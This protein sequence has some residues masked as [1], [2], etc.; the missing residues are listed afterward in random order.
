MNIVNTVPSSLNSVIIS[1]TKEVKSH[2]HISCYLKGRHR[3]VKVAAMVDSGATALF[4]DKK[5][6][7]S[8]KMWQTPLEHPI[9]LHNIDG[10]LN[11]AGSITHKVKLSL[12]VGSDEEIFEFYVT[13]LGPEKVILG[14][15]WL[16]Y[17]NPTINW[18]EGTMHLGADQGMS[19]EPLE[20]KLTRIAAN[21]MERRRLLSEKVMD[22]IQ[23][24]IF[25]LAGFTYSQQIAE[26]ANRAK[27]IRTFEE[28][29]PEP[30]RDFAKVFSEE[31]SHRLPK[32]QPWDHAIDLEPDAITH[33]K[34]KSYPMS[35]AEQVELDKWL[36]ENL[37]KGY[38]RPS[39][40]PMASPVFFIKKKDGKLR[41]VQDYRRLNKIT[42]KDRYPLPLAADIVNRLTGAQLFTK[43]DVR[44]GITTSVLSQEMNG[45]Q[46]S[47]PIGWR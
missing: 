29:V 44:W 23:D 22:T 26:K 21:R 5:Y 18:Q 1:E 41:L 2:F 45:K 17:R 6:A 20:I 32:H 35:P 31:E 13:S 11:E 40:S 38:L 42:I 34:I 46:P 15:P 37:A 36:E 30:Y 43:F 33:W 14:L 9:R 7:E 4:I 10:T 12:K 25:C 24:E 19:P 28:M 39:K 47:S 3:T 8:Q 27:G 16:R